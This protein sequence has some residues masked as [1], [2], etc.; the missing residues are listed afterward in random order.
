MTLR[1]KLLS[2][3]AKPPSRA[4]GRDA[5]LDLFADLGGEGKAITI[6]AGKRGV[7]STGCAIAPPQLDP[8]ALQGIPMGV[9]C[10]LK[11]K[12][13][14]SRKKGVHIL[15]GVCDEGFRGEYEVI[16]LNTSDEDLTVTHGEKVCQ[17]ITPIVLYP[18]VEVVDELDDTDRGA[19]G[20]GSTGAR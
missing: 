13:G 7:V 20:F 1:V 8:Q 10:I 2:P 4:H 9:A 12:S 6:P 3:T 18:E 5:G 19:R 14:L 17:I 16:V 11:D 15:A